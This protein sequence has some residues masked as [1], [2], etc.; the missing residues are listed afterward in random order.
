M[1]P[2]H[3]GV[4]ASYPSPGRLNIAFTPPLQ[5]WRFPTFRREDEGRT[6]ALDACREAIRAQTKTGRPDAPVADIEAAV[7]AALEH[8]VDEGKI[9]V[10]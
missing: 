4:R 1:R 8:L 5:T 9:T 6:L 10:P 3:I 2:K 7:E